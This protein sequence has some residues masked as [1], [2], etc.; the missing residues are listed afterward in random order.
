MT[1]QIVRFKNDAGVEVQV[2]AEDVTRLICP[3]A[4]EKEV[5]LFLAHCQAHHLDPFTKEAYLIKYD[6]SK[7]ASIVTNYNVFN[8]RAQRFADYRG[9]EDGVVILD[10]DGGI[11]RRPGSAVYAKALGETLLGGWARVRR[12]GK[13][14]TYV[15]LALED[16]STGQSKWK[17][18]PGLM[19]NKCAKSA[20][21]RT[22]YPSEFAGMY[23]A[24]EMDQAQAGA[25]PVVEVPAVVEEAPRM[26]PVDE[27]SPVRARFRDFTAATGLDPAAATTV[28]CER[29]GVDD[30]SQATPAQIAD[31]CAWMDAQGPG[32]EPVPADDT[33]GDDG[34]REFM[35]EYGP[36]RM[37]QAGEEEVF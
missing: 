28:L 5:A 32:H 31:L 36:H 21:W 4:D 14:D 7:P 22:A 27:L 23:S 37:A 1:N 3:L 17:T 11:V 26:R 8:A 20:A 9:I 2:T 24:E 18:S 19:I 6:R 15:E 25:A 35:H 34:L 16:Y 13:E 12:D 30:L 29:A 33:P 10:R